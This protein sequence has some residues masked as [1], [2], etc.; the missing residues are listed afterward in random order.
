MAF[1]F[2]RIFSINKSF[3]KY[4]DDNFFFFLMGIVKKGLN[5]RQKLSIRNKNKFSTCFSNK[6][7]N[8]VAKN[9]INFFLVL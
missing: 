7:R 2:Y 9:K 1:H 6:N 5:L 8:F 3:K 4:C